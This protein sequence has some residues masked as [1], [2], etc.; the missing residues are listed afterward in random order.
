[1][2]DSRL[3][4][5][6]CSACARVIRGGRARPNATS[7]RTRG[8]RATAY[9]AWRDARG[10][11][12]DRRRECDWCRRRR[13]RPAPA[14]ACR[15]ARA[16][17]GRPHKC[18]EFARCWQ[19]RARVRSRA[20]IAVPPTRGVSHV[21][22]PVAPAASR[23]STRR[24]NRRTR[25]SCSRKRCEPVHVKRRTGTPCRVQ[26]RLSQIR[27]TEHANCAIHGASGGASAL[28]A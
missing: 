1:M 17:D 28:P 15:A 13:R 20:A 24:R 27:A 12:P 18:R 6:C 8:S 22:W 26:Y 25:R 2:K 4:S 7:R 11:R 3:E 9:R 21:H 19:R 10:S 23:R 5:I 14:C 16:A